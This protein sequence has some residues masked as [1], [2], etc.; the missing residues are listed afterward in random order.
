MEY[1]PQTWVVLDKDDF[2]LAVPR[3]PGYLGVELL[4]QVRPNGR[5]QDHFRLAVGG[6]CLL[7]SRLPVS[8]LFNKALPAPWKLRIARWPRDLT[9]RQNMAT[10]AW[11]DV[12]ELVATGEISVVEDD[13]G[14]VSAEDFSNQLDAG[15]SKQK[16]KSSASLR[17]AVAIGD[18]QR[19]NLLLQALPASASV[20][21][22]KP[23][24]RG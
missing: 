8:T 24:L 16:E 5:I 18:D 22:G 6:S 11:Q 14:E 7:E 21:L 15:T 10:S 23:A 19:I 3:D 20:I 1:P 2:D 9:I 12:R 17:W 13:E 4:A